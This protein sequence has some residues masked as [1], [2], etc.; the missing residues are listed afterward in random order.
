MLNCHE[1]TSFSENVCLYPILRWGY[2]INSVSMQ[3]RGR[4]KTQLMQVEQ[5]ITLVFENY[6]SHP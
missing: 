5:D 6:V 3:I 2:K 4:R 1:Y